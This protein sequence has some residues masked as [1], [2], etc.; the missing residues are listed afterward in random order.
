MTFLTTENNSPYIHSDPGIRI[1]NSYNVLGSVCLS[2]LFFFFFL[3]LL[4]FPGMGGRGVEERVLV[5]D[6]DEV[7]SALLE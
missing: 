3:Y 1:R 6:V 5:E 7:V 4:M 2:T